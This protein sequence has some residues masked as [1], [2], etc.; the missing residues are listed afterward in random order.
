MKKNFITICFV[1]II[2]SV[3]IWF[4]IKQGLIFLKIIN[5]NK[6]DSWQYVEKTKDPLYDKIMTIKVG[7]ENRVNNYFPFY[8]KINSLYYSVIKKIDKKYLDD[9]YLKH[10]R[11]NE[12]I[13]YSVKN[14]FYY[15]V[16]TFNENDLNDMLN[17]EVS[18]YNN[19]AKKYPDI[20]VGIYLPL[21]YELNSIQNINNMKFFPQKFINKLDKNIKV[22]VLDASSA[23]EYL[24]YFY[25]TDHHFNSY[26]TEKAYK[27]ILSMYGITSNMILTHKNLYDRYY[28][29]ASKS[30]LTSKPY[31]TFNVINY[32]NPLEVNIEDKYFKPQKFTENKNKFYDYYVSY[33][34]GQ[35]DEVIYK[36][37]KKSD[38]N[39]LI[40]SDSMAW[41]VDY[42]LATSFNTTYVVNIRYGKWQNNN[43]DLDDYIKKNHITHI[44]FLGEAQ[45]LMFDLYGFNLA[46]K[47]N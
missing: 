5:F 17:K 7:I 19:I 47:V 9:I 44:L 22:K 25:K 39:L 24:K 10:N 3:L 32:K 34:N 6:G 26:G 33:F 20:K 21:R 35:Y 2:F 4:P 14:D 46:G 23:K 43:L 15:I 12:K 36:N 30:V 28:G 40:I 45:N 41:Q 31:D 16:N 1:L 27:D 38:N 37:K 42:L 11:D 8:T 18:Y 13:F 29:S